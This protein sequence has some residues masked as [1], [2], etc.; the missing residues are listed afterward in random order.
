MSRNYDVRS[1]LYLWNRSWNH[2]ILIWQIKKSSYCRYHG[3][4]LVDLPRNRNIIRHSGPYPAWYGRAVDAVV[5]SGLL[6]VL[7]AEF[8]GE[9]RETAGGTEKSICAL[10][11]PNLPAP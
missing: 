2:G 7:L 6:A 10:I 3:V 9:L 1:E 11:M 4:I 5:I 8:V